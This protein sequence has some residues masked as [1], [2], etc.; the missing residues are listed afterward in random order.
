MISPVSLIKPVPIEL[1]LKMIL[2]RL[3]YRNTT[4]VLSMGQREKLQAAIEDGFSLCETVGCWR[5]ITIRERTSDTIILQDS[6]VLQSKSLAAL[7][8][9]SSDVVFMAS[10]V[11]SGIV[12]AAS[13]AVARSDG[14]TAVIYDAVGGQCAD[15]V[16]NWINDFIRRQLSRNMERLTAQRFS[17]G[18]GDLGLENQMVIYSLLQLD[19]LNL[20]LTSRYMLVPEKSVTAIA[21]IENFS[22][23]K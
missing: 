6:S 23:K 2:M 16:M 12:D 22:Q 1:P 21:G 14:A 18:Y 10:T 13:G 20:Q 11:G 7:L 17:P 5:R 19:R 4:T 8:S 15:A 3:G 9:D